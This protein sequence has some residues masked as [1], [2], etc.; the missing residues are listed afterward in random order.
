MIEIM[1]A[2]YAGMI[3]FVI[4][5]SAIASDMGWLESKPIFAW[6]VFWVGW[7]WDRKRQRLY[8]LFLPM[9]GVWLGP[10]KE[11][12]LKRAMSNVERFN[13][14]YLESTLPGRRMDHRAETLGIKARVT[15]EEFEHVRETL[16]C[17]D[18]VD[19]VE[20]VRET[21]RTLALRLIRQ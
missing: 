18:Y 19:E 14:W 7:Y 6:Y 10:T 20:M 11:W 13:N 15:E 8:I 5:C 21:Q 12:L 2:V 17:L 16:A 4:T 9:F 1:L 3:G